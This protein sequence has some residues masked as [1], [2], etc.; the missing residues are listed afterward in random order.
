[1]IYLLLNIVFGS[2][3]VLCIKWVQVR[4]KED[5]ITIGM[6]NY[7]TG[8]LAILPEFMQSHPTAVT[9]ESMVTGG[10]MGACKEKRR[11]DGIG[12][13]MWCEPPLPNTH[14][15]PAESAGT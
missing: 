9:A 5:V 3:F 8:A 14:M 11:G 6:I 7:I 13:G 10:T 15:L 2:L 12:G 1:M 4:K